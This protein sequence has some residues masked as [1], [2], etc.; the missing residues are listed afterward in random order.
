MPKRVNQTKRCE[1][2]KNIASAPKE[3]L[4]AVTTEGIP[5][6]STSPSI[7]EPCTSKQALSEMPQPQTED[8]TQWKPANSQK[9]YEKVEP[10]ATD[11]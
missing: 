5:K 8:T 9:P 2:R 1:K 4:P 3:N 7:A 11:T 6:A 10:A